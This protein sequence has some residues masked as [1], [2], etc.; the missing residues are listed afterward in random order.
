MKNKIIKEDN[1]KLSCN[2][3]KKELPAH[4]IFKECPDCYLRGFDKERRRL[5]REIDE[6]I[7]EQIEC[8]AS[9]RKTEVEHTICS[10][11]I[12]YIIEREK[13]IEKILKDL[14]FFIKQKGDLNE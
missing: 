8:N 12:P 13:I 14:K 10:K 1:E 2:T 7:D 4:L 9:I 11:H 3:C 6:Q 5:I